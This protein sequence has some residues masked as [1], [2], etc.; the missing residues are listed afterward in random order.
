[1]GGMRLAIVTAGA[2]LLSACNMVISNEPML[3]RGPDSPM[4]KPGIWVDAKEQDCEYDA[5]SAPDGWPECADPAI[6]A[7]D[8]RFFTWDKQ[9][10]S[11]KAVQMVLGSG[12][13]IVV[14][15]ELPK[16]LTGGNPMAPR[17][18]Y[19]AM[20]ATDKD[21]DGL[22]T[23]IE[24][25][26]VYC[27]PVEEKG[28]DE[29]GAE[30]LDLEAAMADAVTKEPFEGLTVVQGN[31]IAED[32]AAIENAAALSESMDKES[33]DGIGGARWLRAADDVELD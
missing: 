18:I 7:E 4:M 13:P 31:C 17:F 22:I 26:M 9:S 27:G 30:N 11:W 20:R 12:D 29:E 25:W 10:E 16:E 32:V 14:Q 33:E 19:L 21:A 6:V 24:T 2:V 28:E 23:A 3:T 8:G 1:M 15:A 5:S